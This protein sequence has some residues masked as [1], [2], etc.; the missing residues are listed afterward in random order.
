MRRRLPLLRPLLILL[1][2]FVLTGAAVLG[3][4]RIDRVVV[5]PGRLAGGSVAVCSPRDGVVSRVLARGGAAVKAGDHLLDLDPRELEAEAAGSLARFEGLEAQRTS[6]LAELKRTEEAVQ[7]RERD[8]AQASVDRARVE[9]RRTDLEA[10]AT[11]RLG[12]EGIVGKL[13]VEKAELDRKL[14]GMAL[15]RAEQDI[16]LLDAQQRATV[17]GMT[18]EIRRLE[19]EMQ[20]ESVT[21]QALLQSIGF[22]AIVAPVAGLVV[23]SSLEELRGRAVRK[24]DEVLRVQ[25]GP[26]ER[27]EGLL[28]D[29][30]R[31][32]ARPG[33]KV[34]IRLDAYPWLIH[35]TLKGRVERASERR[36][37]AGGFPVEIEIDPATS[38]GALRE[39]MAGTARIVVEEKISIGRLFLERLTGQGGP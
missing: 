26:P 38:P 31:A 34:R 6:K 20:A 3:V 4:W 23:G 28:T 25:V 13:Q 29:A 22:S 39:G 24:G 12:E 7:P 35:G 5:A 9:Q 21:R 37:D 32:A 2:L 36:A 16:R 15:G 33:Q 14:A 8:E 1:V 17:D 11:A 19:G 27:F 30:G 18:A 10:D